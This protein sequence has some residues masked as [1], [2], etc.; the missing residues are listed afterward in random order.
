MLSSF[1]RRKN[2]RLVERLNAAIEASERL[3]ETYA[4]PKSPRV[5]IDRSYVERRQRHAT[6]ATHD[7]QTGYP[8]DDMAYDDQDRPH[9]PPGTNEDYPYDPAQ[10]PDGEYA[11]EQYAEN[12][13]P[14][15]PEDGAEQPHR[16]PFA[17]HDATD[18][19][20]DR[21][22]ADVH[23]A[24]SDD[25]D[26]AAN[27]IA[28]IKEAVA[29]LELAEQREVEALQELENVLRRNEE[30]EAAIAS[31]QE[32]RRAAE[33]Q[34]TDAERAARAAAAEL[35]ALRAAPAPAPT[36]L[37]A[38]A[39]PMSETSARAKVEA[40]LMLEQAS[41]KQAEAQRDK[42]R[43]ALE[44]AR[45]E[46]VELRQSN[47]RL[48][49]EAQSADDI[50]AA[51]QAREENASLRTRIEELESAL[52]KS[53]AAQ[54]RADSDLK[55]ARRAA[56]AARKEIAA[57]RETA[58][59]AKAADA[60]L[61]EAREREAAATARAESA[62]HRTRELEDE[63]ASI[64][65][66]RDA[67]RETAATAAREA[68]D[69]IEALR[70]AAEHLAEERTKEESEV[71]E[72][73]EAVRE[74][75]EQLRSQA[76]EFEAERDT[77]REEAE[78]FRL[79]AQDLADS[80]LS[81]A[82]TRAAAAGQDAD[83][84]RTRLAEIEATLDAEREQHRIAADEA[85][86][87]IEALRLAAQ[88]IAEATIRDH[89]DTEVD[90]DARQQLA[91][92]EARLADLE[93][94]LED[95]RAQVRMA[96]DEIEALRTAD[97][98]APSDDRDDQ[99][100]ELHRRLEA[101]ETELS[102]AEAARYSAEFERDEARK[103]AS[104]SA[105][106]L[107]AVKNQMP[108]QTSSPMFA[109]V[110]PPPLRSSVAANTTSYQ[111]YSVPARSGFDKPAAAPA[112]K[113]SA[114][115]AVAEAFATIPADPDA[116]IE[117]DEDTL[118]RAF[119]EAGED[120]ASPT[121]ESATDDADADARYGVE[122]DDAEAEG[123]YNHGASDDADS[124]GSYD[125][126]PAERSDEPVPYAPAGTSVAIYDSR[127]THRVTETAAQT[128]RR[129]REKRI[130]SR[131]PVTLWREEWGQPLSCF[132]VDK[133]SRGAK[134]EMKPDRIFGGSNRIA[135]GERL[136]LTFYYAQ[137]RTSVFCDVMWMKGNF[138]GVKYYGQFHTEINKPKKPGKP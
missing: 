63:I 111:P 129:G 134:I 137:E 58:N 65:S 22:H 114:A 132:L 122:F 95:E 112:A 40:K 30:L 133:S 32:A 31:E 76:A 72:R 16:G 82:E 100:A 123:D 20:D 21:D 115:V 62:E 18:G 109:A 79:S 1:W 3:S 44:E 34:K 54:S 61:A 106:K 51:E 85:Q 38:V 60:E 13:Y 28:L 101:L 138:L 120:D 84:L 39:P 57:L 12:G 124:D 7:D 59:K 66:E 41:R 113:A 35:N 102:N 48:A 14:A 90:D 27:D 104:E 77:A 73:Y 17:Y 91:Q 98:Q 36:P 110:E 37:A 92:L 67:E 53:E 96:A 80:K 130:P 4:A 25:P 2:G 93:A 10:S 71:H 136:T 131:M 117:P 26:H 19:D 126:Q 88:E 56:D 107:A 125:H 11:D 99:L 45:S 46:I 6:I 69:E 78:S 118:D 103:N 89:D 15:A 50:A 97:A 55:A 105:T 116:T 121:A 47:E 43:I 5:E 24:D 75:L 128:D 68:E 87:E 23:L 86:E 33:E 64:A 74:E 8:G 52:A 135:V 29:Q 49:A 83:T 119:V 94:E 108:R 127:E 81:E 70:L 42:A 9:A